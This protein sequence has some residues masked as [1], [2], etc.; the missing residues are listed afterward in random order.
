V[1]YVPRYY[2]WR[3][4]SVQRRVESNLWSFKPIIGFFVFLAIIPVVLLTSYDLGLYVNTGGNGLLALVVWLTMMCYEVLERPQLMV[5][6]RAYFAPIFFGVVL[7]VLYPIYHPMG[8]AQLVFWRRLNDSLLGVSFVTIG[9]C[10]HLLLLRMMP[11]RVS[12]DDSGR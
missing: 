6:R 11:E 10:D 8:D 9:L 5:L 2:R 12:E 4:G 7:V 1:T 3:F